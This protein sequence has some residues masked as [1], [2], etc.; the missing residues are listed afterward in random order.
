V[1]RAV[2][3]PDTASAKRRDAVDKNR[4]RPR[5]VTACNLWQIQ[6]PQY[7]LRSAAHGRPRAE[8][9]RRPA[10]R[11]PFQ[12]HHFIR[13]HAAALAILRLASGVPVSKATPGE[14]LLEHA[15]S[16]LAVS[17]IC[18][19][20]NLER[21]CERIAKPDVY[22][23]RRSKARLRLR[24]IRLWLTPAVQRGSKIG[25]RRITP[26]RGACPAAFEWRANRGWNL[27]GFIA[28]ACRR[29]GPSSLCVTLRGE[30][31]ETLRH[32]PAYPK[33]QRC[34]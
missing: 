33:A 14:G 23:R 2:S 22:R 3:I 17:W 20:R 8:V 32:H 25:S 34:R 29:S 13:M 31:F 6:S 9:T 1:A 18:R 19:S 27:V 4:F 10:G 28:A 26:P 5:I 24:E 21:A 30:L 7:A 16:A 15:G 11:V 12:D